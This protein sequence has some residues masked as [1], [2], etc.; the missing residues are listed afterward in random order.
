M[1]VNPWLAKRVRIPWS[2]LLALRLVE[3]NTVFVYEDLARRCDRTPGTVI[4]SA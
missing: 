2:S 1:E 3:C 4:A